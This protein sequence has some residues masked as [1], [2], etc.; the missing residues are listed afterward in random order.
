M[1]ER[2]LKDY[3]DSKVSVES[4]ISDLKGSLEVTSPQTISVYIKRIADSGSHEITRQNLIKLCNDTLAGH[5]MIKDLNTLAFG[6]IGS[7]YFYWDN[8][9]KD[10]EI[11]AKTLFD[12]DNPEINF[13]LT[14]DNLLLWREYLE[15]GDYKLDKSL[16]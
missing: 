6:L 14:Y 3:F 13:E 4:L 5:L 15:T 16:T 12:W 9:T 11:I 1:T 2:I 10:G 7:D 8:E